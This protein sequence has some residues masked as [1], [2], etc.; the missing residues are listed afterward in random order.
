VVTEH[1]KSRAESIGPSRIMLIEPPLHRLYK[2]TYSLDRFS[3]GLGYLAGSIR[4][5][6]CWDVQIYNGDFTGQS[7]QMKVAYLSNEG[8]NNYLRNLHNIN[9]PVWNEVRT[10]ISEYRPRVVGITSKSE[11]FASACRVATIAKNL[12]PNII[13]VVGGPHP[14]SVGKEVM[15]CSAI[16]IAVRGEGEHTIVDILNAV[17]E[18]STF[19]EIQGIV[20]C[21]NGNFVENGPRDTI[22]DL[23]RLAFPHQSAEATLK[24]YYRYP[25]SAFKYIFATRGCPYNCFYCGSREIWG[26]K[27]RFRSPE[28]VADEIQG[29]QRKGL[30][31]IHFSDDTFGVNRSYLRCLCET[32]SK[33]CPGLLW[34]CETHVNLVDEE[35]VSLMKTAGCHSIEI[36]IE[37]GNNEILRQIRKNITIEDALAACETIKRFDI[38]VVALFMVGFPD[39][40]EETLYD[41]YNAIKKT[42]CDRIH[43]SIFTP[44]PGTEAFRM[45][46]DIGLINE[47]Y[48]AFRYG[49]QSPENCFFN[50]IPPDR[51]REIVSKIGKMVDRKNSQ[52]RAKYLLTKTG[53]QRM[54]ELGIRGSFNKVSRYFFGK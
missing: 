23:D 2:D 13:V 46:K 49:F 33:H 9:A 47:N 41:T 3:L 42:N 14:S 17:E 44:F 51:F 8:F 35:T 29:L 27:V 11:N 45:C 12:D 36:G 10:T 31:L 22:S 28:N 37:S 4:S 43:F 25:I 6:T 26:R 19:D 38:E 54:L 16:D 48:D 52:S 53:F 24:D 1:S 20:Y 21:N 50:K 7:E 5:K 34:S 32:L 15:S 39:E 18:G 30:R 40:T